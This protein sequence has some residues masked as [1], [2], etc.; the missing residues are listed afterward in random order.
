MS[1]PRETILLREN[2]ILRL[3]NKVKELKILY[4]VVGGY[5]VATIMKRFSVDLDLVMR[6]EDKNIVEEMLK[7]EG[8]AIAYSKEISTT[9]GENF[10]RYEK[11]IDNLPISVDLMINGLVS[12]TTGASWSFSFIKEKSEIRNLDSISLPVPIK[13]LLI[14][15]KI[16]SGRI[17]DVKD[18]VALSEKINENLILE[19]SIRGKIEEV[20]K[21]TKKSLSYLKSKNFKD[22]FQGVF[23]INAYKK[24]LLEN[25]EKIFQ[26]II[27]Y[28]KQTSKTFI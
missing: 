14:A 16:H 6:E 17:S 24:E 1:N 20:K 11:K 18:I 9:Y 23:T 5:A 15:M 25:A 27:N 28:K 7:K 12:R 21:I 26:A 22:S 19:Y 13:E 3:L 8:Y 2:E 4:I 10:I